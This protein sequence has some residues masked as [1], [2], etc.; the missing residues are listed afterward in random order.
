[1]GETGKIYTVDLRELAIEPIKKKSEKYGL[2]NV[3]PL[4]ISGY[5]STIPDHIAD[6]V[7]AMELIGER[8]SKK[9]AHLAAISNCGLI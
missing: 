2:G 5:D 4:L 9:N 1:M 7:C 3:E 6:G 8:N